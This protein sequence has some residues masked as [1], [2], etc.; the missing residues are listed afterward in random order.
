[1]MGSEWLSKRL[2]FYLEQRKYKIG[3]IGQQH[4]KLD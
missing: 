1:M 2:T 4:S 3:K